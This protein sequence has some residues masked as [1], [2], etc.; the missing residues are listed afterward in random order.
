[1]T[2]VNTQLVLL[3]LYT[4]GITLFGVWIGRRVRGASDFFVAGRSLNW[5]LVGGTVLAAN[6][7]AGTTV[8]AAGLAYR[9]GISAWWWNG[10]VGIGTLALAF[11]V[12]PK[13]WALASERNYLTVG[14]FLEDRYSSTIRG[15]VAVLL[16][17]GTLSILA[18][19][20]IA[21][22][23]VLEVV[24]G[25]PR[26]Q[27]VM[28]GGVAMTLYF[29]AGG[30]LSSAWVNALQLIVL[31][32]GFMVALPM[33]LAQVGGFDGITAA[34]TVPAT[35]WDPMYSAGA[36]SGWTMLI[37]LTPGFIISP[38]VVQKTWGAESIRALR[39][40]I[41]VA[42]VIQLMFSF[43]P[44]LLGMS[45][46]VHYPGIESPNL[47]LPTVLLHELP[48]LVGALALSAV[49]SAEVSTCDAI[50]FMLST[51]S[52]KDLY[53]R[54]V[55]PGASSTQIL[56]VAR[57]AAVT[58]GLAGMFLAIQLATVIDALSIFYS[59]MSATLFVPV[60]AALLFPTANARDAMAAIVGGVGTLLTVYFS[61][62]GKGWW[63][64]SLWGL[65][66]SGAGFTISR[67]VGF[68]RRA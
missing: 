26:W 3:L 16:L 46:R 1:V 35:F 65:M 34:A 55:N 39:I 51:S 57:I 14:D 53:Q 63:D 58:G 36:R 19:Q 64:P 31:L 21:G 37:L 45:A 59:L 44:V 22:A 49:F 18:G 9:D 50:L 23:A 48:V 13:L 12:G 38:G 2:R 47:V 68:T 30:L 6:I 62:T 61:T 27:G 11:W 43:L 33:V 42:A 60:A 54:F 28:I 15:V 24:G 29:T 5:V 17:I 32:G 7:G 20:L 67:L 25:M 40:G 52:S 4:A 66:G 8:G 41:C 56:R 10:A